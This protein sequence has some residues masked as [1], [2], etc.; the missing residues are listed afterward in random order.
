MQ[1]PEIPR[2]CHTQYNIS[3]GY[4]PP[5]RGNPRFPFHGLSQSSGHHDSLHPATVGRDG[6]SHPATHLPSWLLADDIFLRYNPSNH[7]LTDRNSASEIF[8]DTPVPCSE[9]VTRSCQTCILL[10]PV[11]VAFPMLD[12][13]CLANACM[14]TH[15]LYVGPCGTF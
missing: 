10:L 14:T 7:Q 2:N 9:A 11:I 5:H 12:A 4:S 13:E 1:P 3:L 15:R 8:S 6:N